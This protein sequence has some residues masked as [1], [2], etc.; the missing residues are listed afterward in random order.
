MYIL[1]ELALYRFVI[2]FFFHE[3]ALCIGVSICLHIYVYIMFS[4]VDECDQG[5][6]DVISELPSEILGSIVSL[7]TLRD[8]VQAR[9][10]SDG[11]TF[12]L[13]LATYNF[14]ASGVSNR[15]TRGGGVSP[16]KYVNWANSLTSFGLL[17]AASF[18]FIFVTH[19]GWTMTHS[20]TA[21]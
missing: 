21:G 9:F 3:C 5:G 19:I 15:C 2:S 20:S 7:L 17:S 14:Y 4:F 12:G 18:L 1:V 16:P 8:V 11:A 13:L 6:D 10:P